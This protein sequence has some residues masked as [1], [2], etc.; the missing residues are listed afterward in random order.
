MRI[1]PLRIE[2]LSSAHRLLSSL[3]VS[4]EGVRILSPKA[5]FAA[6]KIEN[7]NS[8][9]A[10]IIK[11]QLLSLGS[12]AALN[13]DVLVKRVKTSLLIFG[14]VKQLRALSDKL[15]PQPFELKEIGRRLDLYLDNLQKK[16]IYL[17]AGSRKLSLESPVICGIINVTDDSFSGDGILKGSLRQTQEAA[18][19]QAAV[20][21]KSGAAIIDVGGESTRP[22]A[23]PV[24]ESVEIK[25]VVPVI[26]SLRREFKKVFLSVDT[27]KYAVAR[28]AADAGADIINDITA[29]RKSPQIALLVKKYKLGCVLMHM[30]GSP[31]TMQI[32]PCYREV[33]ADI[34][35]FFA[36]RLAYCQKQGIA[37]ENIAIDPGIGFG[38]K[39]EDNFAVIN[40]LETLKIFA[41][42]LFVGLSRKSFIGK[43]LSLEA[44]ERL[45]PTIAA[46]ALAFARGADIVRVHDAEATR[47]AL[48][49][50]QKIIGKR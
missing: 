24:K 29:L 39:A 5:V 41:R 13:R 37:G 35:D 9:S 19:R 4:A 46:T 3:G 6:F 28:G 38:K 18:L 1:L 16:N 10:N 27:Y 21:I 12:D 7:I 48:A 43:T 33:M 25:R 47:Q 42:P 40:E 2:D 32:K 17:R 14:S 44:P 30:K 23:R 22:F 45:I 49:I 11:Q 20:M 36:A 31:R 15:K 8:W 50:V 26:K 34:V